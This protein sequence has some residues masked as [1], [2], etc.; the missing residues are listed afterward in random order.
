MIKILT[1]WV[2]T[3]SV[4]VKQLSQSHRYI[5]KSLQ[6]CFLLLCSYRLWTNSNPTYKCWMFNT[7]INISVVVSFIYEDNHIILL[8]IHVC[9]LLSMYLANIINVDSTT[10]IVNKVLWVNSHTRVPDITDK[11]HRI[12]LYS[13]RVRVERANYSG[14]IDTNWTWKH[15]F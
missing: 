1:F 15:P 13:V 8:N 14:N 3:C 11:P 12:K 5:N 9:T 7:R 6:H 10:R 4:I 2:V